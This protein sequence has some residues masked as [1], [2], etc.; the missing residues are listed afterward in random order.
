M[1]PHRRCILANRRSGCGIER[2]GGAA[3]YV[4]ALTPTMLAQ[5]VL[6]SRYYWS[7]QVSWEP[8][9]PPHRVSHFSKSEGTLIAREMTADRA[10]HV[11][12]RVGAG[13]YG[14]G[15]ALRVP[16][17]LADIKHDALE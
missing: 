16:D 7:T 5:E 15:G 13:Q 4:W 12:V 1:H 2:I 14:Q 17:D 9:Q 8:V 6:S 10:H 3:T 11:P